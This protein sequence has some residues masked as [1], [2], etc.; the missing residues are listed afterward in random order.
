MRKQSLVA[1]S[2]TDSSGNISYGDLLKARN[3]FSSDN[4][5]GT[6]S[7]GSVYKGIL[8][9]N[10][11]TI[12]VKVIEQQNIGAS[13]SFL[14]EC[15]A[16]RNI[17]HRNIIKIISACASVDFQGNDFKALI[18]EFMENGSLESWLHPVSQTST[19]HEQPKSLNLLQR[20]G[21]AIDV[22]C[23]LD[24]LHNH[25]HV[26]IIHCD[27]KPSNILLDSDMTTHVGDFGLARLLQNCNNEVSHS[28][29]SSV[30]IK[31]TI[32][33]TAPE[34]GPGSMVSTGGDVYSYEILLL[35]L[36]TG[37]RPTDGMFKDGLTLHKLAKL[38]LLERVMEIVDEKLVSVV[39]EE[40]TTSK[41]S[42]R[43]MGRGKFVECLILILWIGVACFVES[44]REQ[45]TIVDAAKALHLVKDMLLGRRI[46]SNVQIASKGIKSGEQNRGE[47]PLAQN[48]SNLIRLVILYKYG[49]VH[50][51]TDFITLKDFSRLRNSI[52]EQSI[53]A[54]GSWTRLN[55]AVLV[56]D[57][58]TCFME[59]F[60]SNLDGNRWGHNGPYLVSRVVWRM[61]TGRDSTH[62]NFTV[63]PPMPFYP[64]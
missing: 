32:G 4:L 41:N 2:L 30:G 61:E 14:A 58:N 18:Y 48:L 46:S 40:Q 49:G 31:G 44:P 12:A 53:D 62:L 15:K 38:A 57:K 5:I 64:R 19:T 3:G 43:E 9:P 24:Y 54:T 52:K 28:Q 13:K 59:E 37:Q 11:T 33:Y 27:I 42:R 10:E 1:S 22:A 7:F 50:L 36:F 17:R 20:L 25:C 60:E 16:L 23:A 34:Y 56:F 51:D 63:L 47:I 26:P 29:N 39:E 35:E 45:M 8:H 21:I 55:N 6:G